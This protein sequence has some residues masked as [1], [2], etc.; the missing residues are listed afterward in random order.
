MHPKQDHFLFPL[1]GETKLEFFSQN[2]IS[3]SR[4]ADKDVSENVTFD[5]NLTGGTNLMDELGEPELF[6]FRVKARWEAGLWDVAF[7]RFPEFDG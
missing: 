3:A 1:T 7:C 5:R 2:P 6:H 4:R